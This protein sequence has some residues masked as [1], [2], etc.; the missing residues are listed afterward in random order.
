MSRKQAEAYQ[1]FWQDM[2]HYTHAEPAPPP[3]VDEVVQISMRNPPTHSPPNR[4]VFLASGLLVGSLVGLAVRWPRHFSRLAGFALAGFILAAAV[5][6]LFPTRFTSTAE[7]ILR[8]V[9][10]TENPLSPPPVTPT[11]EFVNEVTQALNTQRL[12]AMIQDPKLSLYPE[13]RS[14]KSIEDIVAEM[15]ANLRI[16][17]TNSGP[18]AASVLHISF[19]YPDRL[20]AQF[21]VEAVMTTIAEMNFQRHVISKRK[22][23][24]VLEVVD[25]A[26]LPIH[27]DGPPRFAMAMGGL[28]VGLLLGVFTLRRRRPDPPPQL[29]SNEIVLSNGV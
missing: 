28:G 16:M 22:T 20:K 10:N 1:S 17:A 11:S 2:H 23:G 21:A 19:S 15:R 27:P 13:E 8:P 12:T 14:Q 4:L 7:M 29:N 6:F 25:T 24:D 9:I 18:G 26:N 5:S 3:P